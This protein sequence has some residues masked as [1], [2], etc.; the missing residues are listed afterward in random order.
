[1]RP[2]EQQEACP[3][4]LL[5]EIRSDELQGEMVSDAGF[6]CGKTIVTCAML[7]E[8]IKDTVCSMKS[9]LFELHASRFELLS[10]LTVGS[11][12]TTPLRL[13]T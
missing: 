3:L 9:L 11:H 1:V 2:A 12:Q 10:F 4:R 13:F 6:I 5:C 7:R 8:N